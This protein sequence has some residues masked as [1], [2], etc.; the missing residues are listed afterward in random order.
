MPEALEA[1]GERK[2]IGNVFVRWN[3]LSKYT[4]A[5]KKIARECGMEDVHFHH[6]RHTAATCMI[7]SDIELSYVQKML[8]H[9]AISTTQI[10]T[11]IV[12][13]TLKE[14]MKKMKY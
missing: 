4:K 8:G 6:L 12:Q 9:S 3:D 1:M 2:D 7:E 11:K 10:Y 14:K 13:K 5:F